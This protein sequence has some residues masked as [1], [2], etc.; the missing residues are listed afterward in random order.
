MPR[1]PVLRVLQEEG[2][3]AQVV[4]S[5]PPRAPVQCNASSAS[6]DSIAASQPALKACR[7]IS[8]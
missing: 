6:K 5:P 3:D 7:T 8:V 2:G 1:V 4:M